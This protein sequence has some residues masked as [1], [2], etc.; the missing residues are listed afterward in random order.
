MKAKSN[1]CLNRTYGCSGWLNAALVCFLLVLP[2]G[3]ALAAKAA[4]FGKQTVTYGGRSTTFN[5]TGIPL[6]SG[7]STI[8]VSPSMGG[9]SQAGNYGFPTSPLGPTAGL[10]TFGDFIVGGSG[11]VKYPFKAAS[12]VNATAVAKGVLTMGCSLFTGGLAALACTAAAPLAYDWLTRSGVRLNPQTGAIETKD[13]VQCTGTGTCRQYRAYSAEGDWTG[14][15]YKACQNQMV[16]LNRTVSIW[17]YTLTDVGP[18]Y[19]DNS[20]V[21]CYMSYSKKIDGSGTQTGTSAATSRV[22]NAT[23][24]EPQRWVASDSVTVQPYLTSTPFSPSV[25]G[26]IL[27][28]GGDLDMP[29][30]VITGPASITGPVTTTTNADGSKTTSS[31]VS[32]FTTAGNVVTNTTNV[33]TST[34]LNTDN[35]VRST[36]ST[37]VAPTDAAPPEDPCAKNPDRIGCGTLD[38]PEEKIPKITKTIT[39][40]EEDTFG[41]GSC[42]ADKFWTSRLVSGNFKIVDWGTFCGYALPIRAM[43]ILLALFAAFLIVMP[44]KETRT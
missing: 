31:T 33:S 2:V 41:G 1:A 27:G 42:P 25:V 8:P 34:T 15:S 10:N 17:A 9:W 36:T 23:G 7:G 43:V 22:I 12:T 38:T 21:P 13:P 14:S 19:S 32:N 44:G 39:Y 30:P 29:N 35:S 16:Y 6:N 11:S 5:A 40:A 26:E 28:K 20:G 3:P 18:L 24:T 37:S 4:D